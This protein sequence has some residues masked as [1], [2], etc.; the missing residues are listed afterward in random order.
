MYYNTVHTRRAHRRPIIYILF[1]RVSF[2]SKAR[3]VRD[4]Q[5]VGQCYGQC[6][7]LT[8]GISICDLWHAALNCVLHTLLLGGVWGN[9]ALE[10]S[11]GRSAVRGPGYIGA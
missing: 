5:P 4:I 11:N 2:F 6:V 3:R 1:N 10:K 8:E 9:F 7:S